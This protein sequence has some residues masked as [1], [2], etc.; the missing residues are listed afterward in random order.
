MSASVPSS[1]RGWLLKKS[2]TGFVANWKTRYFSLSDGRIRYYKNEFIEH[3]SEDIAKVDSHNY[4]I[5]IF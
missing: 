2:R 3:Y 5:I 4:S 1:K